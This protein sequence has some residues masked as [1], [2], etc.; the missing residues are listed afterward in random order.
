MNVSY[1]VIN[2]IYGENNLKKIK[3]SAKHF[4]VL[5]ENDFYSIINDLQYTKLSLQQIAD[6][7]NVSRQRIFQIKKNNHVKRP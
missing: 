1:S 7:Y 6:K 4:L 3:S 5:S 2:R